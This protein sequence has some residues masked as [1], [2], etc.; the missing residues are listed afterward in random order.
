MGHLSLAVRFARQVNQ[1]NRKHK[2]YIIYGGKKIEGMDLHDINIVYLP[3]LYDDTTNRAKLISDDG[4]DVGKLKNKRIELIKEFVDEL[5]P[6][7][8]FIEHFPFG[9]KNFRDEVLWLI[10]YCNNNLQQNLLVK[11]GQANFQIEAA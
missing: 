2:V 5:R 9:K 1:Q 6:E 8:L 3:T 7:L 11:R 10:D 4:S